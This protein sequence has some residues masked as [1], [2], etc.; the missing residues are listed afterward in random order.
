MTGRLKP[1]ILGAVIGVLTLTGGRTASAAPWHDILKLRLAEMGSRNWIIVADPAYPARNMDGVE[2]IVT[3]K[4]LL[5]VLEY[6]LNAVEEA[7]HV[8]ATVFQCS[9]LDRIPERDAPG[10]DAHRR[11]M[12]KRL[13]DQK[14]KLMPEADILTR[15]QQASEQFRVLLLKCNAAIPYTAISIELDGAYWDAAREERLRFS[16]KQ[17]E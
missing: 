4:G 10:I 7:P 2:L 8:K 15:I 16:I 5:S 6:V 14:V 12:V 1:F 11:D 9:E 13:K 17:L 3:D